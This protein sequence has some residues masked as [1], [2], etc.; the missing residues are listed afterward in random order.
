MNMTLKE[1]IVI[2]S[3]IFGSWLVSFII[4]KILNFYI[5]RNSIILKADPTN[6]SFIKNSVSFIIYTIAFFLIIGHIPQFKAITDKLVLGAGIL[7]AIV[8]FASQKAFSNIISGIFILFFKPYRV[9][10]TIEVG[11]NF[12]GVVAEITLRHTII[13][14]YENRMIVI[15]NSAISEET[16]LNSTI[17]DSRIR[18]FIE[19][20]ISYDSDYD[21]AI[22]IIKEEIAKHKNFIDVRTNEEKKKGNPE[23]LT[24]MLSHADSAIMIRAYAWAEDND[25]AFEMKCDVLEAVKRRFDAEGVEIPFPHRT[26]YFKNQPE[27]KSK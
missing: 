1:I 7:T 15:P 6:F 21:L 16:I 19:F 25:K 11:N 4:R 10:D 18:K 3:I 5:K 24:R 8:G 9:T 17:S 2:A 14:D 22:K 12:K 26:I 13:R 23:V 27:I 20:G